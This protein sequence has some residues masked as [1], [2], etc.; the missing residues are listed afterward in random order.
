MKIITRRTVFLALAFAFFAVSSAYGQAVHFRVKLDPAVASDAPLSGR[1]LIFMRKDDGKPS[2]GFGVDF[3]N[4]N[5]VWISGTEVANF[6]VD[7]TIEIDADADAFPSRFS[8]APAGEYQ[9]FALLD[10]DHSYTYSEAGPGDIYSR[11]VRA[12]MSAN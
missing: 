7:R 6:T 2:D 12:T 1:L 5:A 10:R 4:P 9:I 3:T 8:S 11:V